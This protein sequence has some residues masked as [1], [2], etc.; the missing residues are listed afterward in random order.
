[1]VRIRHMKHRNL[2][3]VRHSRK[4]LN[5]LDVQADRLEVTV[6]EVFAQL[7]TIGSAGVLA[8][9]TPEPV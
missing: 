8:L 3:R 1:M 6:S 7:K 4:L 2:E 9:P 5:F